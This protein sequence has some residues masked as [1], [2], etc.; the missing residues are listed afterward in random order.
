ME[1][2]VQALAS[3]GIPETVIAAIGVIVGWLLKTF[4]SPKPDTD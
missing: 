4:L 3:F 1:D 2:L